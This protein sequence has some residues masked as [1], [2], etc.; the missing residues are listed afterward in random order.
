MVGNDTDRGGQVCKKGSSTTYQHHTRND[1]TCPRKKFK[2]DL[3]A[4]LKQW[5]A[6]GDRLIL[7]KDANKHIFNKSCWG[8]N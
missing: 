4:Q 1:L 6:E 8:K 5:R 7:A 2:E 3:V